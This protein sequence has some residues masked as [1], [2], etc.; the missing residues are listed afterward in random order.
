[1]IDH[2]NGTYI[3]LYPSNKSLTNINQLIT[4][5]N[6][7]D[8]I[9]DSKIHTTLVYS[10][11]PMPLTQTHKL[12]RAVDA[13][14]VDFDIWPDSD[15]VC[16][17]LKLDSSDCTSLH[18]F[19]KEHYGATHDYPTYDPHVTLSYNYQNEP[20]NFDLIAAYVKN[21]QFDRMKITPLDIGD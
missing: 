21:I 15:K 6:L 12:K 7:L 13:N 3:S 8:P 2:T 17:V 9:L 20:L 16:L 18:N 10:R 1:M 14:V 11:N 5:L 19:Y 4:R